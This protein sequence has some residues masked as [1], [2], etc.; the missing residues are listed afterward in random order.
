MSDSVRERIEKLRETIEYHNYRYYVLDDPEISDYEYDQLM[1]E[2]I[3]LETEHPEY[4]TKNSPSQRVGGEA[5]SAFTTVIHRVAL[6]SLNNAYDLDELRKFDFRTRQ[7]L[8]RQPQYVVELKIDGLAVSLVYENGVL[9]RGATRGDGIIGEDVTHNI[10]TISSIPLRLRTQEPLNI[11]IRGE[12]FMSRHDFEEVNKE[13]TSENQ[14]PFAN[15]RNAAAGSVRQLDPKVAA[16]RRL[17]MFAYG[18]GYLEGKKAPVTHWESLEFIKELGFKVNRHSTVCKDIDGVIEYCEMWQDKRETL[19]YD[20]DGIVVKVDSI[21]DQNQLGYT[22]KS[23]RWAVAFKFPAKQQTTIVKDIKAQVG[24]TGVLTPLAILEPVEVGG[25]IVSK[26]TLHN[27]DYIKEKDIRI[28]DTVIVQK[29]GDVIPEIVKVITTKRIGNELPFVMPQICP[30]CKGR[31][32]RELGEAAIRCI[33]TSCPS[34]LKEGLQHFVSRDAM[35]IEGIGPALITQLIENDLVRNAADIYELNGHDLLMLEHVREKSVFK[36][37]DAIEKSKDNALHRLLFGLG[38]R[39]VGQRVAKILAE[40][41]GSMDRLMSA[42]IDELMS[43]EEIGETIA[44]SIKDFFSEEHNISLVKKLALL[45]V[46]MVEGK[47]RSTEEKMPLTGKKFVFTGTLEKWDRNEVKQLVEKV[48]GIVLSQVS[49]NT[50]YVVVGSNPGSKAEK[51][52]MLSIPVLTEA[53]FEALLEKD[54]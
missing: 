29:A 48:G 46:N 10:R 18:I 15:P 14:S 5:I 28:G 37:L 27:E 26:A 19:P 49:K 42:D 41:F 32:R 12:V 36:L 47:T 45:G 11:E 54:H 53:E 16:R 25:S 30:D 44:G 3:R 22:A 24:R 2:L 21:S 7:T 20:I 6:L 34:R 1:A 43:I 23:P 51:A 35:N 31:V 52:Q 39:H 33:N 9:L 50:D 40:H 38:I 4:L 17:D 8:G 13:R